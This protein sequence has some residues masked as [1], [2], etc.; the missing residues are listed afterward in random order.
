[1]RLINNPHAPE[2]TTEPRA[3]RL[4]D[5]G[6]LIGF[7]SANVPARPAVEHGGEARSHQ[8]FPEGGKQ[9]RARSRSMNSALPNF[10][11]EP[12]PSRGNVVNLLDR[13]RV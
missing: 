7:V 9:G 10:L 3:V 12:E 1:M 2:R 8:V 11:H 6:L 4:R 5:S 13:R